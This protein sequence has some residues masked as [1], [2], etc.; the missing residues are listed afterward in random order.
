MVVAAAHS[1]VVAG[2]LVPLAGL[3]RAVAAVLPPVVKVVPA[4]LRGVGI[5]VGA[6]CIARGRV[7]LLPESLPSGDGVSQ[8]L[9][10][11]RRGRLRKP[12]E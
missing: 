8:I 7:R 10:V 9:R 3:G 1:T 11:S 5:I 12:A 2:I 6:A 4:I